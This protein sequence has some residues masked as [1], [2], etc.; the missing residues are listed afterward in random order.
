MQILTHRLQAFI[1]SAQVAYAVVLSHQ[2]S[3]Q[4][5]FTLGVE[6]PQAAM[7]VTSGKQLS[8]ILRD[9]APD[10]EYPVSLGLDLA[11]LRRRGPAGLGCRLLILY[12]AAHQE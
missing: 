4:L 12:K 11:V 6:V 9:A 10:H 3:L 1:G 5:L 7:E 8:T 2:R